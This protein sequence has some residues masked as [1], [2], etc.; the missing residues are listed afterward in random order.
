ML[1]ASENEEEEEEEAFSC[2]DDTYA[3]EP[4]GGGVIAEVK[5][6]SVSGQVMEQMWLLSVPHL[7]VR[8]CVCVC[9]C[10]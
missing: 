3:A 5:M 6:V 1:G 4:A 8:V 9:V 7:C 10:A 2:T